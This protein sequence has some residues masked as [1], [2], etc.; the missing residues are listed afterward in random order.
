MVREY[1]GQVRYQDENFG[2]SPLAERYG[3]KRYPAVFVDEALIARPQDFY[4]WG[5][6]EQGKY[7][8]WRDESSHQRF[9]DDLRRMIELRL[10]GEV[11]ESLKADD[12]GTHQ[13]QQLPEFEVRDLEGNTIRSEDLAGQIVLVEFWATWCPPCRQTL[14][15]LGE[16]EKRY[17][18]RLSVLAVSVAS[19]ESLVREMTSSLKLPVHFVLGDDELVDRFGGVMAVP[20]LFLFDG[21]GRT[22]SVFYGAPDDLHE[23]LD[24]L[25]EKQLP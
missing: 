9:R 14:S 16:V 3:V 19:E 2:E 22:V 13:V 12:S 24:G 1:G 5:T 8:P 4:G 18:D 7:M 6:E 25:I 15:W 17:G 10:R 21:Q 23:R 11:I 20:T